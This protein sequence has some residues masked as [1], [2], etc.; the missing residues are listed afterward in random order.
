MTLQCEIRLEITNLGPT[1]KNTV[2][3]NLGK[4]DLEKT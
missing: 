3:P 4:N 1:N 2:V